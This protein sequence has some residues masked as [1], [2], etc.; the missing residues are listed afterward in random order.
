MR[1]R[2]KGVTL[3][4]V[5]VA[6]GLF[7]MV[8]TAIL[9]FYLE[10]SAVSAKRDQQSQ[11]LRNFH[12]GLDKMEQTIRE[13]RVVSVGSRILT[14]MKLAHIPEVNGFPNYQEAPVQY[15]VTREGILQLDGSPEPRNILSLKP[16]ETVLF[17]WVQYNPPSP[18]GQDALRISLYRT[19]TNEHGELLFSRT[20]SLLKH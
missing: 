9:S 15:I 6:A 11:R 4:E 10:A 7:F 14:L 3:I 19:A 1:T 2:C 8:M 12:L 20:I 18:P 13:G 17:G 5:L 16:E